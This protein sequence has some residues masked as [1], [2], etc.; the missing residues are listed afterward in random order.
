MNVMLNKYSAD[1]RK[2]QEKVMTGAA[3]VYMFFLRDHL[4][5]VRAVVSET[6][7]VQ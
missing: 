6:G 5:S 2:L 4:G 3:P 7:T 1:G